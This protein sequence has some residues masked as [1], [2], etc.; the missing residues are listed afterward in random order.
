MTFAHTLPSGSNKRV[1]LILLISACLWSQPGISDEQETTRAEIQA[2]E[3]D[4]EH[5]RTLL[6]SLNTQQAS[7]RRQIQHN[8]QSI[9]QLSSE[10][11]ALETRQLEGQ[12]EVKKLVSRQQQLAAKREAQKVQAARSLRSLYQGLGENRIKLLLNQENPA[13]V[14]RQ[15]VYLDYFQQAQLQT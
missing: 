5:L 10:I 6:D 13:A 1:L 9:Q 7:A 14:S 4:I 3:G 11:K 15:L 12:G 2:L 8:N